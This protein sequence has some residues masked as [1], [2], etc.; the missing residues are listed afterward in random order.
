MSLPSTLIFDA[1]I[2]FN[3]YKLK[4]LKVTLLSIPHPI[5]TDFVSEEIESPE[6]R[7]VKNAGMQAKGL[8]TKQT[9]DLYNTYTRIQEWNNNHKEK[10]HEEKEHYVSVNDVSLI[11]LSKTRDALIL[12]DDE[13]LQK[14]AKR[15]GCS[16]ENL[17]W[18][19]DE[20]GEA[21]IITPE[22][23]IKAFTKTES[24]MH[25]SCKQYIA[26]YQKRVERRVA[27]PDQGYVCETVISREYSR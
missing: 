3:L 22:Q 9:T 15:E 12:T 8:N 6:W 1:N 27:E 18:I 25:C 26:K 7:E 17:K 23:A 2:I 5:T 10:G 21:G 13:D 16:F 4:L 20:L 19:V 14:A 24:I 11:I